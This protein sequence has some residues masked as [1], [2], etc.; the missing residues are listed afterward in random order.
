MNELYVLKRVSVLRR[1]DNARTVRQSDK[2]FVASSKTPEALSCAGKRP[3][4][5][6]DS[7]ACQISDFQQTVDKVRPASVGSRPDEV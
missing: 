6:V 7:F 3:S 2:V 1:R 4:K 5:S